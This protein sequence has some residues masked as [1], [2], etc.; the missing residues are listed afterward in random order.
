MVL[1]PCWT[2]NPARL[3]YIFKR[4]ARAPVDGISVA[5]GGGGRGGGGAQPFADYKIIG[6]DSA[7]QRSF[8]EGH[9][10]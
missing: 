3:A 6:E 5:G 7:F 9:I 1:S 8:S 4:G 2:S 10:S